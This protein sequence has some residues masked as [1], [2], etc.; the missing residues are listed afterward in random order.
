MKRFAP[1]FI[2]I[3]AVL[4]SCSVPQYVTV[5]VNYGPKTGFNR[6][7]TTIVVV[8]HYKPDSTKIR[9][10]RRIS[11]LNKLAVTSTQM[12]TNQLKYLKGIHVIN[13]VDTV[14]N[15]MSTDSVKFL[16]DAHKANYVL[17]LNDITA[18]I[19]PETTYYNGMAS[20]YYTTKMKVSLSLYESNGVYSKKLV[21]MAEVSQDQGSVSFFGRPSYRSSIPA[22][23]EATQEATLDALKDYL[24]FS[25][26][27]ERPLYADNEAL[28]TS[29]GQL[30]IGKFDMAFKILNPLIDGAD[31]KLAGKAAYNLAV[32]YEAQGDI[33]EALKTA[34]LSNQKYPNDLAKAIIIDLL[35]E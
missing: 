7:S 14:T 35:K 3:I 11:I 17:V 15:K 30:K 5:P 29:V 28:A 20:T 31:T 22:M 4:S 2:L 1:F 19:Y 24:P 16:A 34:K 25:I 13:L 18:G 27:N 21:G 23:T 9:D 32:V 12:A 8:S 10:F 26:S 33:D 6:D